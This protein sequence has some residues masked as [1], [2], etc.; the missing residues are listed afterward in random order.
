MQSIDS[1]NEDRHA[2]DVKAWEKLPE[3]DFSDA[4]LAKELP[5]QSQTWADA[6]DKEEKQA[7]VKSYCPRCRVDSHSEAE[8]FA[9]LIRQANNKRKTPMLRTVSRVS[10]LGRRKTSKGLSMTLLWSW[11]RGGILMI[12]S[13]LWKSTV[14]RTFL[15]ATCCLFLVTLLRVVT[16]LRVIAW[17]E[18]QK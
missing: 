14:I 9:S 6:E 16:V 12:F 15:R 1:L 8:C 5:Q 4:S 7:T 13:M 3:S 18:M 2:Q 11:L 17:Q 10:R